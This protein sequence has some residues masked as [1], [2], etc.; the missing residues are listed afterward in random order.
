[1]GAGNRISAATNLSSLHSLTELNLRRNC[2]ETVSGLDRLPAL[3]RVFLSHNQIR[4][5][6]D[7]ACLFAVSH[8]VELSL[9][10]NPFSEADPAAY[11]SRVVLGMSGLRHLDLRRVTDEERANYGAAASAAASTVSTTTLSTSRTTSRPPQNFASDSRGPPSLEP[12]SG[13]LQTAHSASSDSDRGLGRHGGSAQAAADF[14]VTTGTP[15]GS[16]HPRAED[17]SS[18]AQRRALTHLAGLGETAAS[19]GRGTANTDRDA[20]TGTANGRQPSGGLAA[21]ARSGRLSA[22]QNVFELEVRP[23]SAQCASLFRSPCPSVPLSQ[24]IGPDE[25]A[26]IAVG[27]AWEWPPAS[28][29]LLLSVTEAS[30][31]HMRRETIAGRFTAAHLASLTGLR[32][33]RLVGNDFQSLSQVGLVPALFGRTVEHLVLADCPLSA[34]APALLRGHL[35]AA[36]PLLRTFNDAAVSADERRAA[37]LLYRPATEL[38]QLSSPQFVHRSALP[39]PSPRQ[40]QQSSASGS[41]NA[42]TL[43]RHKKA[44]T[45]APGSLGGKTHVPQLSDMSRDALLHRQM[46][47]DFDLAFETAVKQIIRDTLETLQQHP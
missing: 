20:D 37:E 23:C 38:Q 46:S 1:M 3:Q 26:L 8:L 4:A 6:E 22:A 32:V 12:P 14:S 5:A 2:I 17:A 21:L 10:G 40:Q 24:A 28:R 42:A 27:D 19:D 31:C 30:L 9:D 44:N 45:A 35:V 29:R 25:K 16:P 34:S 36:M 15:L 13:S 43:L 18:A 47:A 41:S 39:A 7:M 33:L 11:R